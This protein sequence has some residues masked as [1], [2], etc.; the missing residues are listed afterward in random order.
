MKN[1][2]KNGSTGCDCAILGTPSE[3]PTL[4]LPPTL[5]LL[6]SLR[7]LSPSLTKLGIGQRGCYFCKPSCRDTSPTMALRSRPQFFALGFFL[8]FWAGPSRGRKK[9]PNPK[10]TQQ[11]CIL[12]QRVSPRPLDCF[13]V[14]F[15]RDFRNFA[16][17]RASKGM[18]CR[19]S[20]AR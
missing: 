9:L 13:F 19:H 7:L 11:P 18:R 6:A 20:D 12:E 17:D 2:K 15:L 4:S 10:G 1:K 14:F 16:C 8:G 5:G 3:A